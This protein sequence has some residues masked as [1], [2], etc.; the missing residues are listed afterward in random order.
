[1]WL[2]FVLALPSEHQGQLVAVRAMGQG[3]VLPCLPFWAA[4]PGAQ[5]GEP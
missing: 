4:E 3:G 2:M 5:V 1:M